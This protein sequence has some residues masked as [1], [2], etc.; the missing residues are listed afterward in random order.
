[1]NVR[2][3]TF[4]WQSSIKKKKKKNCSINY[5]NPP[6]PPSAPS[7]ESTAILGDLGAH[8]NVLTLKILHSFIYTLRLSIVRCWPANGHS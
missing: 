8:Q 7:I 6:T 5:G 4:V 3:T 1:M 2:K